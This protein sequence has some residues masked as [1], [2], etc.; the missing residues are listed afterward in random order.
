MSILVLE[1]EQVR[2][3]CCAKQV[4][5]NFNCPSNWA[6]FIIFP[7]NIYFVFVTAFK[8]SW[9][10]CCFPL[11]PCRLVNHRAWATYIQY[12]TS[13]SHLH[14]VHH[15][16]E[17]L[18]YSTSPAW[19]TY[20]QYITSLSHLHTVHHRP[21]PLTYSTSPAW[22]TYIQYITGLSHLH[23]VHH[24]PEPLTYSTSLAWATYI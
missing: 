1:I 14:T 3:V 20:I 4:I 13:L 19:A 11:C 10:F 16:P 24:Q 15:Q 8:I 5:K 21:E 7:N 9:N 23:T 22:A 6:M 17:P 12:T 2:P 18:T